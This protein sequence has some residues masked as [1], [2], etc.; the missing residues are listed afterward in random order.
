MQPDPRMVWLHKP[1]QKQG[2][3]QNEIGR[4]NLAWVEKDSWQ[5]RSDR[6]SLISNPY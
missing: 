5:G 4:S 2:W 6:L 1:I 3:N